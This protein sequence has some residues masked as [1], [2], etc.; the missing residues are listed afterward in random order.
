ML[1]IVRTFISLPAGIARMP[2]WR[3]T[4]LTFLGCLPWNF[5]LVFIGQ[6]V[7]ANWEDWKDSLH[8]VD[9]AVAAM[10][11]GGVAYLIVRNRRNR[12]GGSEPAADAAH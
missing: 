2:F 7:G 10:I 8:Y 12:G 3:F 11:V 9:Y 4:V 1:P 5:M 6:Q